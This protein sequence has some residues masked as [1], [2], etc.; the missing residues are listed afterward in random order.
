[1]KFYCLGFCVSMCFNIDLIVLHMSIE[2]RE[3]VCVRVCVM[4]SEGHDR[5]QYQ[6]MYIKLT[7][8]SWHFFFGPLWICMQLSFNKNNR[9]MTCNCIQSHW[10]YLVLAESKQRK[11]DC[12]SLDE[13]EQRQQKK[14]EN[15]SSERAIWL[16][17]KMKMYT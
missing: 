9:Q 10:P 11:A 12:I 2:K 3:S 5:C 17:T 16:Q 6:R 13:S 7:N 15:K 1:M 14:R 8:K 4:M